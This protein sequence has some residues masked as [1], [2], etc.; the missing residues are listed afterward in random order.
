[1]PS[2]NDFI[3]KKILN[4]VLFSFCTVATPC[5]IASA[6]CISSMLHPCFNFFSYFLKNLHFLP[7]LSLLIFIHILWCVI[8]PSKH[9]LWRISFY[10]WCRLLLMGN[11]KIF[12]FL[13]NFLPVDV[14]L[15]WP[16]TAYLQSRTIIFCRQIN[17]LCMYLEWE[18]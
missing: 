13:Q 1:L 15:Y 17:P 12:E 11:F 10:P 5:N 9:F 2:I 3:F 6:R 4:F 18:K 14:T 8:L 7:I 16:K